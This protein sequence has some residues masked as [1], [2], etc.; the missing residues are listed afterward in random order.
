M[1]LFSADK[2]RPQSGTHTT[3]SPGIEPSVYMGPRKQFIRPSIRNALAANKAQNNNNHILLSDA[4]RDV[5]S[6]RPGGTD[7]GRSEKYLKPSSSRQY[8][9]Q[10]RLSSGVTAAD[11]RKSMEGAVYDSNGIR[12]DRTPT[13]DEINW[14][15]DKVRSCL[16]RQ[17]TMDSAA[18]GSVRETRATASSQPRQTAHLTSKYIDGSGISAQSH[19]EPARGYGAPNGYI[20]ENHTT[21]RKKI[22]MENLNTANRRAYSAGQL[23][24]ATSSRGH[25]QNNANQ[26]LPF[27]TYQTSVPASR[28]T[29]PYQSPSQIRP[30][31]TGNTNEGKVSG[32][33]PQKCLRGA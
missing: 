11:V 19:A 24:S 15:W 6:N 26:T 14:L 20:G 29:N 28:Q 22:S 12:L 17:S 18:G 25:T 5:E 9:H 31:A 23:R 32:F 8:D 7:T 3:S 4:Q 1:V 33:V 2:T 21:M 10:D 16:S 30:A 27:S 13:D